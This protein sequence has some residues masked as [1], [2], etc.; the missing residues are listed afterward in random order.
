MIAYRIAA[1]AAD[2]ARGSLRAHAHDR[3]LSKARFAFDWNRQFELAIDPDTARAMHD[4]TL[5]QDHFKTAEFCSMCGPKFC[6]MHNFKDV[7]WDAI[8]AVVRERRAA[9]APA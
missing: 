3:E 8:A 6:P 4:E 5:P 7:D 1:H 9:R 2:L